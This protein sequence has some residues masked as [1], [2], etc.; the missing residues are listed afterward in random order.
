[1]PRLFL[2]TLLRVLLSGCATSAL[3]NGK[4]PAPFSTPVEER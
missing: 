1:M 4:G 2:L 3:S